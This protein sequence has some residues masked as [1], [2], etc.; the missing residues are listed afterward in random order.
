MSSAI[1]HLYTSGDHACKQVGKDSEASENPAEVTCKTCLRTTA[2]G[3]YLDG[4]NKAKGE[5]RR[6]IV[7]VLVPLIKLS[8]EA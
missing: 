5:A 1:V 7:K 3:F 8:S 4:W 2:F 6:K